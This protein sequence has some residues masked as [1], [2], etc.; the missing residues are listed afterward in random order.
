ME[1]TNKIVKNEI[2]PNGDV[3]TININKTD[4]QIDSDS[5]FIVLENT[6]NSKFTEIDF[7]SLQNEKDVLEYFY[8]GED[9]CI[10]WINRNFEKQYSL[11]KFYKSLI[12]ESIKQ[13][14][15]NINEI[16][17]IRNSIQLKLEKITK[18]IEDNQI[19]VIS[20]LLQ[21]YN[22]KFQTEKIPKFLS[23][24]HYKSVKSIM[25]SIDFDSKFDEIFMKDEFLSL[26]PCY[27]KL[28]SREIKPFEFGIDNK[29]F[30]KLFLLSNYKDIYKSQTIKKIFVD[31][32]EIIVK[33]FLLDSIEMKSEFESII[34]NNK[35]D[36]LYI[37]T[38]IK[39][40]MEKFNLMRNQ[41]TIFHIISSYFYLVVNIMKDT[42]R[43][44]LILNFSNEE[45]QIINKFILVN[46]NNPYLNKLLSN[47][48]NSLTKYS[49]NAK[50]NY[51]SLINS[52][53]AFLINNSVLPEFEC[54]NIKDIENSIYNSKINGLDKN[55]FDTL[56]EKINSLERCDSITGILYNQ[57]LKNVFKSSG[58]DSNI[59]SLFPLN[60]RVYSNTIT[61]FITGFLSEKK[62]FIKYWKKFIDY[63][64]RFSNF[65]F[66]RWPSYSF[67]DIFFRNLPKMFKDAKLKAK[68][69]GKILGEFLAS[70]EIF[71]NFQI[72]LVG[73]SLGCHV[74]KNCLKELNEIKGN[75]ILINN[76][77]FMAGATTLNNNKWPNIFQNVVGGRIINCYSK[78]DDVLTKL[79]KLC[80][81]NNAIGS[82]ELIIKDEKGN[83]DYVENYDFSDL[84]LGHREYKKNFEKILK[85]IDFY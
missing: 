56:K 44:S 63:D 35:F 6:I 37:E 76:V 25:Y 13:K 23:K 53:N 84:N 30:F 59:F 3:T 43:D 8:K 64:S 29:N 69:S 49:T 9:E 51:P 32:Y 33:S 31:N 62:D 85:R 73:H 17:K 72:N 16:S 1:N 28:V 27:F 7:S 79:Y 19:I 10:C 42:S 20:D 67:S 2:T 46:I 4:I 21:I 60:K 11:K 71:N 65:F 70:N 66:F 50:Y 40:L 5:I 58:S 39:K 34:N 61:I 14:Y 82:D 74:I 81:I 24:E 77:I 12:Y 68:Y 45:I 18:E 26:I 80:T 41:N 75:K 38:E 47:L 52:F 57:V 83:F 22:K 55:K 36:C 15:F 48:T 54:Y 78:M